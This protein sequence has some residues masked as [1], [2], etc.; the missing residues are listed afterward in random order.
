MLL[1]TNLTDHWSAKAYLLFH[2]IQWWP[3]IVDLPL[4]LEARCRKVNVV[5]IEQR[6]RV[7]ICNWIICCNE[8]WISFSAVNLTNYHLII[9]RQWKTMINIGSSNQLQL[10]QSW[11]LQGFLLIRRSRLHEKTMIVPFYHIRRWRTSRHNNHRSM[12]N[13]P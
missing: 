10:L 11:K 4:V 6:H 2:V 8:K 1:S 13:E 12:A 3:I 9:D 7:I 5:I